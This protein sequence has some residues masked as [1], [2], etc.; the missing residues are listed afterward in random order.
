KIR[1]E[2][3]RLQ[4]SHPCEIHLVYNHNHPLEIITNQHQEQSSPS[5]SMTSPTLTE[6]IYSQQS[7]LIPQ[8][9]QLAGSSSIP[10]LNQINSPTDSAS[11][12]SS[13]SVGNS[14]PSPQYLE[15]AS[16]IVE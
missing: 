10:F 9:N 1:L 15:F 6:S 12:Y 3:A 11:L 16:Q 8:Q 13:L 14:P 5:D 7:A 2:K 4:L